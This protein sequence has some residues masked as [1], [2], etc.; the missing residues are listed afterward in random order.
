MSADGTL[1]TYLFGNSPVDRALLARLAM[2][3]K[4]FTEIAAAQPDDSAVLDALRRRGFDEAR[5]RRWSDRFARTYCAL[6]PLWDLDEGYV[7]P[8]A[9]TR[10]GMALYRKIEG[11]LMELMRR[12][13]PAP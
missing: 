12:L 5:V 11:P 9:G 4:E 2:T 8:N 10:V 6:I 1:G 13:L 3:T 7:A